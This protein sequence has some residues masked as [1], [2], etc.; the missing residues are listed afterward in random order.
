MFKVKEFGKTDS[1]LTGSGLFYND[2]IYERVQMNDLR[3]KMMF[4]ILE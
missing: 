2:L 4:N 1:P 3:P